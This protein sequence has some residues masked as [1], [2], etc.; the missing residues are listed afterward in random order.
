MQRAQVISKVR[1]LRVILGRSDVKR[2]FTTPSSSSETFALPNR[3]AMI[4]AM[5]KE[6]EF[7]LLVIG[8]GAT[9]SG[10]DLITF[11]ARFLRNSIFLSL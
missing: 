8:G 11:L 9:G 2:S 10:G 7:D 3:A 5:E 4:N 1:V 6:T